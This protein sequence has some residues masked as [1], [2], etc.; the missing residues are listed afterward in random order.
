MRD[1]KL[2]HFLYALSLTILMILTWVGLSRL[3]QYLIP[4]RIIE[5]TLIFFTLP[6][7]LYLTMKLANY[8]HKKRNT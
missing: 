1:T 2:G 5:I 3:Y 4:W 7:L 8:I 6:A